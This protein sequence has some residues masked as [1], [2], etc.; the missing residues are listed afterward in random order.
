[1]NFDFEEKFGLLPRVHF[2]DVIRSSRSQESNTSNGV[3]IISEMKMLWLSEDNCIELKNH[4]E[5][6]SKFNL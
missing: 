2:S 1:M 5:M 6:I 3:Q 4:F